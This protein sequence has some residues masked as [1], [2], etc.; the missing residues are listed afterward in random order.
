MA[1]PS[2]PLRP[3]RVHGIGEA[4]KL[5]TGLIPVCNSLADNLL[6]CVFLR[7]FALVVRGVCRFDEP[8]AQP[9][10]TATA[11]AKSSSR[12]VPMVLVIEAAS[13]STPT[14]RRA[15]GRL[16]DD[17]PASRPFRPSRRH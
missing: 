17:P 8:L 1:M 6:V 7:L 16:C 3:A 5:K 2:L 14:V 4:H 15:G 10:P 13:P 9:A 12:A 11:V